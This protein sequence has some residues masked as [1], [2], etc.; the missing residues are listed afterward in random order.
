MFAL[1]KSRLCCRR[2]LLSGEHVLR[3]APGPSVSS[4]ESVEVVPQVMRVVSLLVTP[5]VE[6]VSTLG[7]LEGGEA[8]FLSLSE[9]PPALWSWRCWIRLSSHLYCG[10][11]R[12][13]MVVPLV[14]SPVEL[15]E[16]SAVFLWQGDR[17]LQLDHPARSGVDKKRGNGAPIKCGWEDVV[18]EPSRDTGCALM[19]V[20]LVLPLVR[21][22]SALGWFG[23]KRR[24]FSSWLRGP[25][26][27]G[28]TSQE[29]SSSSLWLTG[30]V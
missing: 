12:Q 15:W 21:R 10:C 19:P 29:L 5:W 24:M 30:V 6:A 16:P 25:R 7:E 1:A 22:S 27:V 20:S 23:H 18:F 13:H 9:L 2:G 11:R 17:L 4:F 3:C 26:P 14:P 28:L 8:P